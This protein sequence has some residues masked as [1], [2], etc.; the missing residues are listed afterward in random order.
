MPSGGTSF[1]APLTL[2]LDLG[3][4][5]SVVDPRADLLFVTDGQASVGAGTLERIR[6][7]RAGGLRVFGMTVNGGSVSS[8]VRDVCDEVVDIDQEQDAGAAIGQR[9]VAG[10]GR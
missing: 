2:A 4:G 1:D 3:A 8:A 5:R 10:G 7:A 6:A 9:L